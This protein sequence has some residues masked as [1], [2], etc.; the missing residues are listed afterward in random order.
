MAGLVYIKRKK[1]RENKVR[2]LGFGFGVQGW[3]A[4]VYPGFLMR[5]AFTLKGMADGMVGGLGGLDGPRLP[6][7]PGL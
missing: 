5:F 3:M 1:E 7:S 4:L 2:Y 6:L